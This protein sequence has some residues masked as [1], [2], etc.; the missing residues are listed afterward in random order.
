MSLVNPSTPEN[1][2]PLDPHHLW[3][4]LGIDAPLPYNTV[5]E[6]FASY[7]VHAV[8][9]S[10]DLATVIKQPW[11]FDRDE[12]LRAWC[13]H[14]AKARLAVSQRATYTLPQF[15]ELIFSE[16]MRSGGREAMTDA[17][18]TPLFE[19]MQRTGQDTFFRNLHYLF[20]QMRPKGQMA[21]W[22]FCLLWDRASIP[23]EYWSYPAQACFLATRLSRNV[24]P[25][26]RLLCKWASRM[27]LT[28][29]C[30]SVITDFDPR[31][32][33]IPEK[34]FDWAALKIHGIPYD[35]AAEGQNRNKA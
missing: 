9:P 34:G 14:A 4:G 33:T 16:Q 20:N 13:L 27:G 18:W 5:L 31:T 26:D 17:V 15:H 12:G 25:T 30:P 22:L 7:L 10:W 23:L 2:N 35:P 19:Y 21:R 1:D 28:Q 11:Y 6:G 24:A 32:G 3:D 29:S 8:R